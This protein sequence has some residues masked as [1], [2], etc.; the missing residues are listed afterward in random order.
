MKP[1]HV[2]SGLGG[3]LIGQAVTGLF[4][5]YGTIEIAIL[6]LGLILAG[7]GLWVAIDSASAK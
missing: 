1:Y 5:G 4:L 2:L 6:I 7:L 3:G